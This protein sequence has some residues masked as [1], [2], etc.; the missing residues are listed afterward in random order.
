MGIRHSLEKVISHIFFLNTS[1]IRTDRKAHTMESRAGKNSL[2]SDGVVMYR[3]R[4]VITSARA[5]VNCIL[6]WIRR[7][8]AWL[9]QDSLPASSRGDGSMP[10]EMIRSG[11]GAWKSLMPRHCLTRHLMAPACT[12]AR[13]QSANQPI[14]SLSGKRRA[15]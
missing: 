15:S 14:I 8:S 4:C 10:L 12:I 13:F 9:W 7:D 3:R 11:Q 5:T 6:A 2:L 1:R